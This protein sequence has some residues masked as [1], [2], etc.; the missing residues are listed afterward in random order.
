MTSVSD[1]LAGSSGAHG[2]SGENHND[3]NADTKALRCH[4]NVTDGFRACPS[5][6]IVFDSSDQQN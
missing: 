3:G 2:H 1:T 5:P 4:A 6:A